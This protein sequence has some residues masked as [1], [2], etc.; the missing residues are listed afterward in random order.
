MNLLTTLLALTETQELLIALA[1]TFL[2]ALAIILAVLRGLIRGFSKELKFFILFLIALTGAVVVFIVWSKTFDKDIIVI[3]GKFNVNLKYLLNTEVEH[4][5]LSGYF[6][7]FVSNSEFVRQYDIQNAQEFKDFVFVISQI[8]EKLALAII[9]YVLFLVLEIFLFFFVYLIFLSEKRRKKRVEKAYREG[10]R[11]H[12][13]RKLGGF[14]A[15]VGLV[16]GAIV[17]VILLS[18]IGFSLGLVTGGKYSKE[19][20]GKTETL[21]QDYYIVEEVYKI[22]N[23]Y[24]TTGITKILENVRNS[25]NVPLYLIAINT[26]LTGEVEVDI[27]GDGNYEV[28]RLSLSDEIS[29]LTGTVAKMAV[30]FLRYGFD[31]KKMNEENYMM[32]FLMSDTKLN[33][34]T[35]MEALDG[36]IED[37]NFGEF[38]YYLAN[39]FVRAYVAKAC[40]N[41]TSR[42]GD[43]Y[44]NADGVVVELNYGQKIM[45]EL[46]LGED[47]FTLEEL[48]GKNETAS[49]TKNNLA[50]VFRVLTA[51]VDGY[52]QL[53]PVL[54]MLQN[55]DSESNSNEG[56]TE[57]TSHKLALGILRLTDEQVDATTAAEKSFI[58]KI[59]EALNGLSFWGTDRFNRILSVILR[60]SL[61]SF[62]TDFD[63]TPTDE[64][65]LKKIKWNESFDAV[66]DFLDY[67]VKV[68][69]DNSLSTTDKLTSFV[70]DA[71]SDKTSKT[72]TVINNIIDSSAISIVLNTEG[73]ETLFYKLMEKAVES[74]SET[75]T[76][77]HIEG[78]KF[79][80]YVDEDGHEHSGELKKIINQAGGLVSKYLDIT[81]ADTSDPESPYYGLTEEEL[82]NKRLE[83]ILKAL[84]DPNDGVIALINDTSTSYSLL[85]HSILSQALSNKIGEID[86][87][88]APSLKETIPNGSGSITLVKSQELVAFFNSLHESVGMINEFGSSE[89]DY[90]AIIQ[91]YAPHFKESNLMLSVVSYLLYDKAGDN[92]SVPEALRLNDEVRDTNINNW[93]GSTG[94]MTKLIDIIVDNSNLISSLMGGGEESTDTNTYLKKFVL[95]NDEAIEQIMSSDLINCTLTSKIADVSMGDLAILIPYKAYKDEVKKE[96]IKVSEITTMLRFIKYAYGIKNEDDEIDTSSFK[97]SKILDDEAAEIIG[98]SSILTATVASYI[99]N[100][101]AGEAAISEFFLIPDDL[102]N[103]VKKNPDGTFYEEDNVVTAFDESPWKNEVEYMLKG[104]KFIG[105]SFNESEEVQISKSQI[106]YLGDLNAD[107]PT[108]T[109]LEVAARSKIIWASISHSLST[110]KA[111][112]SHGVDQPVMYVPETSYETNT[113]NG[114]DRYIKVQNLSEAMSSIKAILGDDVD[115]VDFSNLKDA[116]DMSKYQG[117]VDE[118]IALVEPEIVS[119]TIANMLMTTD[120]DGD[121]KLFIPSDLN[122]NKTNVGEGS[123]D[124]LVRW[125][126]ATGSHI[127]REVA[128]LL[129]ALDT[130]GLLSKVTDTSISVNQNTVLN[131]SDS[132][133]QKIIASEVI[134]ATLIKMIIDES[135]RSG[136]QL[137]L[138]HDYQIAVDDATLLD[139][140]DNYANTQFVLNNETYSLLLS[141]KRFGISGE[142]SQISIDTTLLRHLD[143]QDYFEVDIN[144]F[145]PGTTYYTQNDLYVLVDSA[146]EEFS[147]S[148]TYY[149][150]DGEKYVVYEVTELNFSSGVYYTKKNTYTVVTEAFDENKTYY[151]T[152]GKKKIETVLGSE[153]IWLSMSKFVLDQETANYIKINDTLSK[154]IK[155]VINTDN[156][157]EKTEVKKLISAICTLN[158]KSI[159]T[160]SAN[161]LLNTSLESYDVILESD[162][163]WLT[164]SDKLLGVSTVRVTDNALE[165]IDAI[166][167]FYYINKTEIKAV[168]SAAKLIGGGS[169]LESI[170]PDANILKDSTKRAVLLDSIII[171][172]TVSE[173]IIAKGDND[174]TTNQTISLM[175]T[176]LTTTDYYA[177]Y[178]ALNVGAEFISD[179]YNQSG[180]A[181]SLI[182]ITK[183]EL[184]VFFEAVNAVF[185][186]D[187][188]Y[189]IDFSLI[190]LTDSSISDE[191]IEKILN[192]TIALHSLQAQLTLL[193]TAYDT[194]ATMHSEPTFT[195]SSTHTYTTYTGLPDGT[196]VIVNEDIN[197]YFDCEEAKRLVDLARTNF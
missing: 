156:F 62:I 73:F 113:Y 157:I 75:I 108:K 147:T 3:L 30:I 55:R 136:S 46:F 52:D 193:D 104:I 184:N 126:D 79:G 164:L 155:L 95:K 22:A 150:Y 125:Y 60:V 78:V 192:S 11:N 175:R 36:V 47:G 120:Q 106:F 25:D 187:I 103:D 176:S 102:R 91:E 140:R 8:L 9:C 190:S 181:G 7:E 93:I 29:P 65:S 21:N 28:K 6:E 124:N 53:K 14:G 128:K 16:R 112:D 63:F 88:I 90:V 191:T 163:L 4:D 13:Y 170:N 61:E 169:D 188:D 114:T 87:Y 183:E 161:N 153:I 149:V 159:A 189:N 98:D 10:K 64:T 115:T 166:N 129:R 165:D 131:L 122:F 134:N 154:N 141:M 59:K 185:S 23:M 133:I 20:Q 197:T 186:G 92:I 99:T 100:N 111:P 137:K 179:I 195:L 167:D 162:I 84:T 27:K 173:K 57:H 177:E 26:I 5:T 56:D 116:L 171:R 77:T 74:I 182:S 40:N 35:L 12:G 109:N 54:E 178:D 110:I 85:L 132:S 142:F 97:Y 37:F 24:G 94:E 96:T 70:L 41:A 89:P 2:F 15:L 121:L 17:G 168:I 58:I 72:Y 76:I 145:E 127:D 119:A 196:G 101:L 135:N 51:V 172:D 42:E 160:I 148:E 38:T 33:D 69:N 32:N 107:E 44:K 83:D 71:L 138:P 34:E 68:V 158:T 143:E 139:L 117:K 105:V 194:W 31:V 48:V 180:V 67:V 1:P 130:L 82:K 45:Y 80:S 66:F 86:L 50:Q 18:I 152:E 118:L 39:A 151:V 123:E 43:T 144:G 49:G 146:S 19:E 81:K 174:P